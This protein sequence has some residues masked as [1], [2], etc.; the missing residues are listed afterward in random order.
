MIAQLMSCLGNLRPMTGIRLR[1]AVFLVI[2]GLMAAACAAVGN[3]QAI[4][5]ERMLAAAGFQVKFAD[6]PEKLDHLKSM[7]QRQYAH[8]QRDDGRVF[9]MYA[10]ANYC[11]CLYVG[12]EKAYQRY[13]ELVIQLE[14][15]HD[16][17]KAAEIAR[18]TPVYMDWDVWGPWGPWW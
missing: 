15:A 11:K 17:L 12:T 6:T 14:T 5:N 2:P 4:Q 9:Y 18:Q 16:Q 8:H 7:P 3:Q 13:Q 1:A 10:D